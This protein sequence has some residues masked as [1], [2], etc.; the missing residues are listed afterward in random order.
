[1]SVPILVL[2][3]FPLQAGTQN[4]DAAVTGMND[5]LASIRSK[6]DSLTQQGIDK[7]EIGST[8][9]G[10]KDVSA[11]KSL[12]YF[13]LD[14]KEFLSAMPV[15]NNQIPWNLNVFRPD[16]MKMLN[17]VNICDYVN[18]SGVKQV[19]VW[20]YHFGNIEPVESNMAMGTAP[21]A[22]WN[23]GTYG[24]V[25]NS[26]QI[27][28]MPICSKTY[29]LYNYNYGRGLGELLEDH[30]HQLE[31]VYSF[32]DNNLWSKFK[33]PY[34]EP[35]PVV[36]SCGWTHAGPNSKSEYQP[37]WASEATVKSNCEDWHPDGSGV[38]NDVNCHTW[39]GAACL[40]NG[41]VEFKIW[42]MQNIP[43]K[44]NNLMDGIRQLRNWWDFYGDFDSAVQQ[45]KNL[46]F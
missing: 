43:G 19:W 33:N 40:D 13:V 17:D 26:E 15:S 16:Y 45:G 41:G 28:D 4:L 9:H 22:F 35:A 37:G 27:N 29:T 6:V 32:V 3:Y 5:S 42:W 2:K 8:Y 12:D 18:N 34:G 44:D 38:I 1:M 10:Y 36:N 30:G 11:A 20:G 31:S 21:Q 7:M 14:T 23:H 25:S 39:Y 46:S 24:D